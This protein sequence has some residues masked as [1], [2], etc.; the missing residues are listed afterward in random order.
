[1]P[2]PDSKFLEQERSRKK[3]LWPPLICIALGHHVITWRQKIT[4]RHEAAN[5]SWKSPL[6]SSW[7]NGHSDTL[8][9]RFAPRH[10]SSHKMMR[11]KSLWVPNVVNL[12]AE[13]DAVFFATMLLR[14]ICRQ[15]ETSE[16]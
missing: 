10:A 8:S 13:T 1:L 9:K 3:G 2:E 11:F 5:S 14:N 12:Y 15:G 6:L 16:K 4:W 7:R